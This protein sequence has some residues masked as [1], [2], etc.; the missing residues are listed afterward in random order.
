MSYL[1]DGHNLIGQL[2][3][4][5]LDDP[6]DEAKL[7]QRLVGW[8]ARTRRPC[9]VVFDAGLPGG[10]SRMST[11]MVRV[12]FAS[13]TSSADK[14]IIDRIYKEKHPKNWIVVSSDNG[15]LDIAKRQG[16][17]VLKSSEFARLLERPVPIR[18]DAGEEVHVNLSDDEVDEWLKL[19]GDGE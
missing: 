10:T 6:D 17:Q 16:M 18:P 13:H 7:V 8:S 12:V 11:Q 4:L 14:V 9:T 19:F 5:A 1:I 2:P 15:V 3:D